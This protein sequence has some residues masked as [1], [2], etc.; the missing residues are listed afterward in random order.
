MRTISRKAIFGFTLLACAVAVTVYLW[1]SASFMGLGFPLDDAWIHQT[2]ARNLAMRGEWAFIPGE[3][4]TG[5]TSPLWTLLLSIGYLIDLPATAYSF[6]LGLLTLIATVW[7]LGSSLRDMPPLL[8]LGIMVLLAFEWHVVWAA[9]SGMETLLQGLHLLLILFCL[10]RGWNPVAIGAL[11]GAGIWIRPDALIAALPIAWWILTEQTTVQRQIEACGFGFS[12]FYPLRCTLFGD[13]LA[14][15][16]R[17]VA[18]HV[19]RQ[20]G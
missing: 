10:E 8:K 18:Q 2:Y 7:V 12:G 11:A 15:G 6:G 4:S 5:S 3:I 9:V 1:R 17:T 20:A 13:E 16:W 19:L 14:H